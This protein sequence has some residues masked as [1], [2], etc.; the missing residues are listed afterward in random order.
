VG[1]VKVQ[2]QTVSSKGLVS[3]AKSVYKNYGFKG[4]YR[5]FSLMFVMESFGRGVYLWTYEFV[6]RFLE[7]D[8]G[9]NDHSMTTKIVSA[10]SAGC[11]SWAVVYPYDVIKSRLQADMSGTTYKSAVHCLKVTWRE[12][13]AVSSEGLSSRFRFMGGVRALHRGLGFTL[14]RAG[15]C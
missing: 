8:S 6:K 14:L 3:C 15:T 7:P 4:F 9:K 10:A 1:L 11:F 2:Q 13:C 5:G 12:G